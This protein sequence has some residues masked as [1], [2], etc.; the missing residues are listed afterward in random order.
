MLLVS[1]FVPAIPAECSLARDAGDQFAL[2]DEPPR[3][4]AINSADAVEA[5][6]EEDVVQLHWRLLQE[7]RHL[8]EPETPLDEKIDTL[9][10]VFTESRKDA[11]PFSFANCLRVVGLSPMSP[12]A[13]F[14]A[15]DIESIRDW[16][17]GRGRLW[18]RA[19][20]ERYPAWVRE[21]IAADPE[22]V[23]RELARDPQWI[24][25]Q[26]RRCTEH[27]DIFALSA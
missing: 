26:L 12:T 21:Q 4:P 16:I 17:R 24:N 25:E 6:S 1:P 9:N 27:L 11:L 7:L 14:G 8:Q 15:V 10:W 13:Y 22:R 23:V 2:F 19:T 18:M 5:W 20:V 3:D